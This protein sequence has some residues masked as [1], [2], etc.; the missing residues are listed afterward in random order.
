MVYVYFIFY[1][2]NLDFQ[3]RATGTAPAPVS[4]AAIFDCILG[5]NCL[6]SSLF[7]TPLTF[8]KGHLT[9]PGEFSAIRCKRAVLCIW[10]LSREV[11]GL[12]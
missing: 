10:T 3:P 5:L 2:Y 11:N 6:L 7:L 12:G 4:H 8:K 1:I 9:V